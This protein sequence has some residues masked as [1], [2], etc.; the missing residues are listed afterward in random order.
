MAIYLLATDSL[1]QGLDFSSLVSGNQLVYLD[2]LCT[3][4]PLP[5]S[6]SPNPEVVVLQSHDLQELEIAIHQH[7][8]QNF[9]RDH[10]T[11][12]SRVVLILDGLD[13]LLA[14]QPLATNLNLSRSLLNLRQQVSNTIVTCSADSPLLHNSSA[15]ATPLELE[16]RAFLTSLAHQSRMVIQL[17]S[18]RTGVAKDISGILRVSAGGAHDALDE[19][20]DGVEGG[21]WLYQVKADG[22]VRSWSRGE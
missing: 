18:L 4:L 16:H 15:A 1:C 14:S 6:K 9:E 10:T 19:G 12:Q 13:Y 3:S 5:P 11:T 21:E 22:S 7:I 17:R 20:E 2:G 8:G